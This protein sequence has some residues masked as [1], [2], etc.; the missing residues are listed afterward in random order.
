MRKERRESGR[1][2]IANARMYSVDATTTEAWR[3]LLAWVMAEAGVDAEVIDYPAPQ[4][5][6]GL[7]SRPD[8]GCAFMCG[9]PLT[10]TLPAPV[11]LAAPLPSPETYGGEPVYWTNI[12]ARKDG[13]VRTIEDALGRR[14]AFT[15]YDS[16]SGYHAPRFLFAPYA[17]EH[18]ELFATTVGPLIT[19]RGVIESVI[20]GDADV[21]PVDSYAFDLIER[22]D[23]GW[24]S[25]IAVIARTMRTPIPPLVGAAQLPPE[26]A[27]RLTATLL[28]VGDAPELAAIRDTLLLRGFAPA[29]RADYDLLRKAAEA[30]DMLGYPRLD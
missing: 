19:P 6:S 20:A 14:M 4:P 17:R 5:L 23:A 27:R 12:V 16:Q 29:F 18:P 7:W 21:G 24:L 26:D 11:V 8:L 28:S 30:A 15:T 1:R 22:H 13:P 10:W 9:F 25:S 2:W 3:S